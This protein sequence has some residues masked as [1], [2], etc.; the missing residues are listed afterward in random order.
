MAASAEYQPRSRI[1]RLESLIKRALASASSAL[2][3]IAGFHA[4]VAAVATVNFAVL[5]GLLAVDGVAG[6][7]GQRVLLANQQ[8]LSQNGIWVQHAGA[9][10]RPADWASASTRSAGEVIPVAP[11]GTT[12][13]NFGSA[14]VLTNT[15]VVDAGASD[16]IIFPKFHKG[17]AV[18]DGAGV[19]VLTVLWVFDATATATASDITVGAVAAVNPVALAAGA[20]DGRANGTLTLNGTAAH[21][22]AFEVLNF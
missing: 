3:L 20:G 5:A 19:A 18:L 22:I 11:G 21:T 12:F 2:A 13:V 9:W 8:I 16:P 15:I 1:E 6:A 17:T 7:E 10:T 4:P 14:W